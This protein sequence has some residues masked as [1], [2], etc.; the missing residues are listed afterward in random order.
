[1]ASKTKAAD[2]TDHAVGQKIRA[3]RIMQG[4][5]QTELGERVGV[6]FQQIQKY[7]KG[8][9][10][11]SAGRLKQIAEILQVPISFFF[12][13]VAGKG[14]V[15]ENI[16]AGLSFLET[17]ASVGLVRAFA[18]IESQDVRSGI[19]TLVERIVSSQHGRRK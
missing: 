16:N 5:S 13:G 4:L 7:E 19:V 1:M 12:D 10:R 18:E 17:A 14:T 3:Q 15:A 6:T 9:N 11:V 8:S 2:A